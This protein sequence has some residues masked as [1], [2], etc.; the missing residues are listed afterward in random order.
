VYLLASPVRRFRH[1]EAITD[2]AVDIVPP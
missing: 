2:V 1:P